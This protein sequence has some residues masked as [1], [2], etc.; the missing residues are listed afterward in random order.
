[1]I[2]FSVG[3]SILMFSSNSISTLCGD[4]FNALKSG[5]E[6]LTTGG[7]S[8]Y[9]PPIGAAILAHECTISANS[10]ETNIKTKKE[11]ILFSIT[12]LDV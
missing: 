2:T 6:P 3:L 12:Y 10:S 5:I 11:S 7:S 4:T 9:S 1:M 8:S